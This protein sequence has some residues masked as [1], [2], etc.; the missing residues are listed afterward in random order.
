MTRVRPAEPTPPDRERQLRR[1]ALAAV[2]LLLVQFLLGIATNLYET[3]P[4]N[5]PGT[6]G[7]Y[8]AGIGKGIGWAVGSGPIPLALHAALGSALVLVAVSVLVLAVRSRTRRL[9]VS[10][11][12]GL[13]A[14]IA[15]WFN[16][17]SFIDVG[18]HNINSMI[19][20]TGFAAAVASYTVA[21][22]PVSPVSDQ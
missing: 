9:T 17:V 16:G 12:M 1:G 15:A 14:I 18:Q 5:H 3:I 22:Y 4:K 8:F 6:T 7:G 20:S 11:L 2:F 19:M 13:I 10:A 21:L